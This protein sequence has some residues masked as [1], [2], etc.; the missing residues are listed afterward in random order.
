LAAFADVGEEE[1][2]KPLWFPNHGARFTRIAIHLWWRLALLG[3]FIDF[4]SLCA[5]A[6]YSMSPCFLYWR[7]LGAEPIRM[8][9]ATF[10]E[11]AN[12]EPPAEFTEFWLADLAYW[13]D[14]NPQAVKDVYE[15]RT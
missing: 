12:S 11:I 2:G 1:R 13:M 14:R 8:Q 7:A 4:T 15:Q 6:Q 3:E 9:H 10:A 5:G